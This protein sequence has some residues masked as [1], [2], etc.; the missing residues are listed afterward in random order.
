MCLCTSIN[1]GS[2]VASPR[3]ITSAFGPAATVPGCTDTI[4]PSASVTVTG[5]CSVFETPSS[6]C[7]A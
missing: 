3:S 5:P 2:S 7:A 1:P 6:M 4:T